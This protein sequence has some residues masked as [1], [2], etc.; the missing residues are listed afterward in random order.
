[1]LAIGWALIDLVRRDVRHI[2]KWAWAL[3]IAFFL[4][5]SAGCSEGAKHMSSDLEYGAASLISSP[6]SSEPVLVRQA[7]TGVPPV[8]T[9]TLVWAD[10]TT[11]GDTTFIVRGRAVTSVV[12]LTDS[13]SVRIDRPEIP[14]GIPAGL[15]AVWDGNKLKPNA[16]LFSMTYGGV[17][18]QNIIAQITTAR[19]RGMKMVISMTGGGRANYTSRLPVTQE[20]I[21]QNPDTVRFPL[22]LGDSVMQFDLARWRARQ[23]LF[24]TPAIRA[25]IAEGVKDGTIIGNNVM[26]EPFNWGMGPANKANSWGPK[27]TM[28]KA[29]VDSMC[30]Y[31]RSIFPTLPQGVFHDFRHD[32]GSSYATRTFLRRRYEASSTNRSDTRKLVLA[33]IL[34]YRAL[35]FSGVQ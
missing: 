33:L 5:A 17:T 32:S 21:R 13:Q 8:R 28:N 23:D 3:V 31:A 12:V 29:R 11:R 27:G 24:N 10:S 9:D 4:L 35:G 6:A 34:G 19:A 1:V 30:G 25:A 20:Q 26:D 18:P 15:F 2:P 16:D 14:S 7:A 22:R